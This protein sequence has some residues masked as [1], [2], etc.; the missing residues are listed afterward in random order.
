[1]SPPPPFPFEYN[2]RKRDCLFCPLLPVYHK[3]TR[4]FE[5]VFNNDCSGMEKSRLREKGRRTSREDNF[6]EKL[7]GR[8]GGSPCSILPVG[9]ILTE[10]FTF[11]RFHASIGLT[12]F[13]HPGPPW[14]SSYKHRPVSHRRTLSL[15]YSSSPFNHARNLQIDFK[16]WPIPIVDRSA[17]SDPTPAHYRNDKSHSLPD[18]SL[19]I[20]HGEKLTLKNVQVVWNIFV[21]GGD[22]IKRLIYNHRCKQLFFSPWLIIYEWCKK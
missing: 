12:K 19:I 7:G 20:I 4:I 9:A 14:I 16:V 17:E 11:E 13:H 22:I 10:R 15:S 21:K 2:V 6:G 3:C 8:W 1:M 5:R 18:I